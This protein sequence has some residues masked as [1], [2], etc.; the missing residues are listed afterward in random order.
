MINLFRWYIYY[1]S[2][3]NYCWYYHLIMKRSS[4][5]FHLTNKDIIMKSF[6]K[7]EQTF[8]DHIDPLLIL[9]LTWFF[10]LY[11]YLLRLVQSQLHEETS[12]FWMQL[13]QN[14]IRISIFPFT[15]L[16]MPNSFWEEEYSW[17]HLWLWG[18]GPNFITSV[19]SFQLL[20]RSCAE[21]SGRHS[22]N[23][24]STTRQGNRDTNWKRRHTAAVGAQ[25]GQAVTLGVA[26]P[27]FWIPLV[28]LQAIVTTFLKTR[29]YF[30]AES[31]LNL[32]LECWILIGTIKD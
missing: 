9:V 3:I 5:L 18:S 24:P 31:S 11:S 23:K 29:S 21:H 30:S 4:S 12:R 20:F 19:K 25:H 10:S 7:L 32:L 17:S 26:P 13:N 1:F 22:G 16:H 6:L 8:A 27:H 15:L 14:W 2:M 28:P